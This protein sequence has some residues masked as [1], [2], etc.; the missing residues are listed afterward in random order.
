M[1]NPILDPGE[2]LNS[3]APELLRKTRCMQHRR[4]S[5]DKCSI[6]ALADTILSWS[7]RAREPLSD[8]VLFADALELAQ[9]F[10]VFGRRILA[11]PVGIDLPHGMPLLFSPTEGI[12]LNDL[13]LVTFA[14]KN[15]Q[16]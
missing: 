14:G 11:A 16:Q 15:I 7:V 12:L 1:P 2:M 5:F 10:S 4:S 8:A 3:Q 6:K 9:H 13:W